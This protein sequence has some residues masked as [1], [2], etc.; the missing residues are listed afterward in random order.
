MRF[1]IFS[2]CHGFFDELKQALNE[3]GFDPNNKDHWLIGAGDYLDRGTM[4][5][6]TIDFL[7]GLDRC[8]LA[9]G[10]HTDLLMDCLERGYP[11]KY[12]WSNGTAQT[13]CD[14]APKAKTFDAACAIVYDKIKPFV[15]KMVNYVELQ[16]YIITHSFVPLKCHDNLPMYYTHNRKFEVDPDWRF[17]HASAWN[18][19]RWGNPYE[20]AEQGL[21]PDKILIF[22]H[23]HTSYPRHKYEGQPEFGDGADFSIYYGNDYIALDGCVAYSGK[24]N[25]LVLEDEFIEE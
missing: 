12:D 19:A 6:E 21:L 8:K 9:R 14:L 5:Q 10:N 17:A 3:A 20:L 11:N 2:D 1:F 18:E 24:V 16:N 22:G 15:D 4:P 25:V 7:M 23:F 13:I